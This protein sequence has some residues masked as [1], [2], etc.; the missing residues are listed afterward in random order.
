MAMNNGDILNLAE[1]VFRNG[2]GL[3]RGRAVDQN[4]TVDWIH[5]ANDVLRQLQGLLGTGSVHFNL[6]VQAKIAQIT[7]C[8]KRLRANTTSVLVLTGP[9]VNRIG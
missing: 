9:G 6:G 2:E 4:L 5:S 1:N 7:S 3:M 8:K